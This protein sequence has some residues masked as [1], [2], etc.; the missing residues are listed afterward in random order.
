MPDPN[1]DPTDQEM[2]GYLGWGNEDDTP[3]PTAAPAPTSTQ[4]GIPSGLVGPDGQP[5]TS[6]P[7]VVS[8]IS[9]VQIPEPT[10]QPQ[11]NV[12]DIQKQ[13]ADW[14]NQQQQQNQD[15][16][17]R[18]AINQ[19]AQQYMQQQIST[20]MDQ[21]QAWQMAQ[22]RALTHDAQYQNQRSQQQ[23]ESQAQ[24]IAAQSIAQ[25]YGVDYNQL[26]NYPTAAAMENAASLLSRVQK[27]ESQS[28][29]VIPLA[30]VQTID[31][32]QAGGPMNREA[33]KWAY[34]QGKID[35]TEEQFHTLFS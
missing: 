18:A 31:S 22:Q 28:T 34:A 14:Q 4:P 26:T 11:P 17:A 19:D 30:P 2:I 33:Q 20:G 35:L 32:G 15:Q 16:Q 7:P 13:F 8:P 9:P 5:I 12:S 23:S 6:I 3:D 10:T 21:Q 29:P 1:G 24:Q 25:R 27:M